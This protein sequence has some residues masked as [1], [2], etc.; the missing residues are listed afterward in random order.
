MRLLSIWLPVYLAS[1]RLAYM[2]ISLLA[3]AIRCWRPL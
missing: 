2:T 3:V 1:N